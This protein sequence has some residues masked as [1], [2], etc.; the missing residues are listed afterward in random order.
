METTENTSSNTGPTPPAD[1]TQNDVLTILQNELEAAKARLN[2]LTTISQQALADL[3]N[4]KKRTEDEKAKFIAFSNAN[5]IGDLIP[6]MDNIN[7]AIGHLPE[8]PAAKEWAMGII[9][10]TKQLES[11]LEA[12]GLQ[13]IISVGQQFDPNIHEALMT[14]EG[15]ADQII[16]EL[17]TGYRLQ[18]RVLRRAKVVVGKTTTIT[19]NENS[20]S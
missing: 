9:A 4:F 7:R 19:N 1:D 14:E 3:Q 5:L 16:R 12:R 6:V 11:I 10:T 18:D 2:E 13:K 17:E 15:P 20:P 8:D